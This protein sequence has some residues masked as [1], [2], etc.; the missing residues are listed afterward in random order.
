MYFRG[1]RKI[2]RVG[3]KQDSSRSFHLLIHQFQ[4]HQLLRVSLSSSEAYWCNQPTLVSLEGVVKRL[5]LFG[6]FWYEHDFLSCSHIREWHQRL[7]IMSHNGPVPSSRYPWGRTRKDIL[8]SAKLTRRRY[9]KNWY[10]QWLVMLPSIELVTNLKFSIPSP[11]PT[12]RE[13]R[14]CLNST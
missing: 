3:L 8:L 9:S 2:L 5:N 12:L 6:T 4:D 11:V 14:P 7:L 10:T 1:P 13:L